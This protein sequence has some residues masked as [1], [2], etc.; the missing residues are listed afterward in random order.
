MLESKRLPREMVLS[1]EFKANRPEI[2][3]TGRPL[4]WT[5]WKEIYRYFRPSQRIRIITSALRGTGSIL[6]GRVKY[7]NAEG[8]ET[9]DRLLPDGSFEFDLGNKTGRAARKTVEVSFM[10]T[11]I[12]TPGHQWNYARVSVTVVELR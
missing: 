1:G 8:R 11:W 10:S 5:P 7:I 6:N 3:E 9:I 2:I 12:P 4:E